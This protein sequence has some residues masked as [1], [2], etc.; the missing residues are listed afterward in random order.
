VLP[1]REWEDRARLAAHISRTFFTISQR[2][3]ETWPVRT[4]SLNK[5]TLLNMQE[6]LDYARAMLAEAEAQSVMGGSGGSQKAA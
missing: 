6:A 4:I 5:R 1:L 2:T 3:L